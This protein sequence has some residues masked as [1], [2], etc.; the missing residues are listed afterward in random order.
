MKCY[1]I[2]VIYN[3]V[4]ID[5]IRKTCKTKPKVNKIFN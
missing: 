3:D 4:S 1:K 5:D 2:N